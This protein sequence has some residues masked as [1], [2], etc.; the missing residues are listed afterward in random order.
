MLLLGAALILWPL[1][2]VEI[3][4]VSAG[5]ILV[6]TGVVELFELAAPP[7]V[8][9]APVRA[10]RRPNLRRAGLAA[11]LLV[12]LA[13]GA[14]L[15]AHGATAPP[16]TG[17]C[18][19]HAA[20][21]DRPL[22]EVAFLGTHNSM[23]AD[24][25]PGWLFAAQDAGIGAQLDDGVRS[26]LIDTHYGFA[27]P[28]GVATDLSGESES[29]EKVVAEVGERF[30]ET[31]ERLRT[32]IGYEGGGTREIFLCH[33]FCE[34]GATRALPALEG[35]HRFLVTH[36]EEVLILSIQDDTTAQD[37][38]KLIRDSGLVDE[39]YPGPAEPPWPTLRE[40]IA[41]D[42]RVLVLVENHPGAEPW[43]YPQFQVAQETPF[44]FNTALQLGAADTCRPNRGGTE[45]SL[46]L[47]NHWVDTS[48]APRKTI[49]REVNAPE[50]LDARLERCRRER[51]MLP[52][53]VAVDFYRQGDTFGA[54][55]RLNR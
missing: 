13:G 20:L 8:D 4:A 14:A 44:H 3:A 38:A 32:R 15:A 51:K 5:L 42:E 48:P 45:G 2:V 28:R 50:F 37:T 11:G 7:P 26:L 39:V 31:A 12:L 27:T 23:A 41:R 46:L 25:E 10:P 30:V 40:L 49:A 22:N 29:R 19:G 35:V 1:S 33:T 36:P 24:N 52:T 21:C 54:V 9:T 18:N 53:I 34:V 16:V 6:L 43:L 55:D 47:V 17:R